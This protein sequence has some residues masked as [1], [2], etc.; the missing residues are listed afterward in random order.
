MKQATPPAWRY[1]LQVLGLLTLGGLLATAMTAGAAAQSSPQEGL[2]GLVPG[3]PAAGIYG[4]NHLAQLPDKAEL[5]FDYRFEGTRLE[6]PFTDD[7]LLDFTRQPAGAEGGAEGFDVEMTIFPQTRKQVVGPV[8]AT[9][10]NPILLVFFQRDVTHMKNGTGGS[11]HYFR[12][13]IRKAMQTP[14]EGSIK[15]VTIDLDGRQVAATEISFQPFLADEHRA[16]MRG[17]ADKTY[18]FVVSEAVPGGIY[19]VQSETPDENTGEVLLRET[20]RFRE[21]RQ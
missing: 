17:F 5:V 14:D 6:T 16:Q 12:N 8:S 11:Q 9:S 15:A 19:E 18:R 10:Y 7:V 1:L 20:Y 4:A 13:V 21:I 3:S 2:E